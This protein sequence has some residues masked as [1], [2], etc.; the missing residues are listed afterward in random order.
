MAA[1]P[2]GPWSQIGAELLEWCDS[3]AEGVKAGRQASEE[4]V[5]IPA[6]QDGPVADAE[7]EGDAS[8]AKSAASA[9]EAADE[10]G[11]EPTVAARSIT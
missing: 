5:A 11:P 1:D 7:A 8:E 4:A 9:A 10:A 6:L 3:A 2:R